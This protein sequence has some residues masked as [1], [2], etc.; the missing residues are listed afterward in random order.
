MKVFCLDEDLFDLIYLVYVD[1]WDWEKV[2]LVGC[3]NFDYLKEMVNEI[4]KVICLI[5][6]VVEVC[7]DILFIL[8]K[9]IIF[10]YS[11][12]LVKC[13]LDLLGK[14]CEN[15]ICK[16]YGV[17][18]LIGIGGKLLDGKLY[19]GCVLDYDDWIIELENGYKGLNGDIL[20]WND[21][22]GIVFEFFLMGICV[23]EKVLC[24]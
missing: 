16:E 11:E 23:D 15:V 10:I 24:L 21:Q 1:Q 12:D 14:E 19:D 8:L 6:L 3:C 17:V 4:Y 5:E 13:Y 22:L 9:Q 2:I 7:F 20:V 18:F